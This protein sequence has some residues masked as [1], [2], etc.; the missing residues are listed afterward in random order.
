[1]AAEYNKMAAVYR[2]CIAG[3]FALP[4]PRGTDIRI[5]QKYKLVRRN[6]ADV[7][8]YFFVLTSIILSIYFVS[9]RREFFIVVRSGRTRIF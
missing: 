9:Y 8:F 7:S 4:R 2:F 5:S 6:A 3:T 1:M